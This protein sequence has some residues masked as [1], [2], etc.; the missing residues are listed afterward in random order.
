MCYI[1]PLGSDS[2]KVYSDSDSVSSSPLIRPQILSPGSLSCSAR[3]RASD[4]SLY[5]LSIIIIVVVVIITIIIIT[6]ITVI[7]HIIAVV[8]I[9]MR[10]R[11]LS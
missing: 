10:I 4:C 3:L 11:S 5:S 2:N 9:M 6:I 7:V 8:V 1:E